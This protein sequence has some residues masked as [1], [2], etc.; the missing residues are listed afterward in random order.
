MKESDKLTFAVP[1]TDISQFIEI[2]KE[3]NIEASLSEKYK[4]GVAFDSAL[5]DIVID[6]VESPYFIPSLSLA[7]RAY[8]KRND[9][10]KFIVKTKDGEI[11]KI[12]GYS[13]KD[14]KT[15]LKKVNRISFI[16]KRDD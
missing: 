9:K 12:E 2:M 3:N 1:I 7:I 15:L 14:V 10:K 5:Y 8:L 11:V 16:E 4:K 13:E 6:L